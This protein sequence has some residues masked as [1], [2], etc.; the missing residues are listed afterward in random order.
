MTKRDTLA[1]ALYAEFARLALA[2]SVAQ[3][4]REAS[5]TL[6]SSSHG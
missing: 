6:T 1:A 5:L 3:V 4:V 2:R